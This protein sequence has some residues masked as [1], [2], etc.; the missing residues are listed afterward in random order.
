MK[1]IATTKNGYVCEIDHSELEQCLDKYYNKLKELKEG[2]EVD[3]S[4]GYEWHQ[5]ITEALR[6]IK[7][8]VKTHKAVFDSITAG[9]IFLIDEPEDGS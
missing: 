7:D 3:L 4:K 1:I 6:Q 2:E 8:H 5:R 9:A